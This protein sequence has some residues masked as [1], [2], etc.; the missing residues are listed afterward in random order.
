MRTN[1]PEKEAPR[2]FNKA[3]SR[4]FDGCN[5]YVAGFPRFVNEGLMNEKFERFGQIKSIEVK[6]DHITGISRGF[7][8]ILFSRQEEALFAIK[9]MHK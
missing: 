3:N 9:E 6:R 8:Y 2:S 5:V 4:D 7:A 1:S